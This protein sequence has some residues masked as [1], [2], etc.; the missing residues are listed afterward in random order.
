M[1]HLYLSS[2]PGPWA[3][4]GT[5]TLEG[6]EAHHAARVGRLALG[7]ATL[8]GDGNGVLAEA[9]VTAVSGSHVSLTLHRV[10]YSTRPTPEMWLAQ[11]LAK[12]D[13]DE[14]AIQ[15]STELG[16]DRV[17][18]YQAARSISTWKADKIDKGVARW[19]KIVTEATKQ[20]LRA[21]VPVVTGPQTTAELCA[22]ASD[23]D[24]V[25]LDPRAPESL[26]AF[27]PS[28]TR[29]IVVVVGPEGGLTPEELG[30][31]ENAGATRRKLGESVL[32]TSSAGPAALA[33]LNVTLGRW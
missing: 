32:R 2:T 7:E 5:V 12:G 15:A 21:Y 22:L 6:D 14:L 18:P 10:D 33:V 19:I 4:G 23:C 27:R 11:A 25:V 28:G 16:I 8:V 9:T 26:S 3:K 13:R 31:L 20:A 29:P 24:V 17:I 1:A 30:A